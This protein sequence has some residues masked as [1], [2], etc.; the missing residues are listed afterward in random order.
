MVNADGRY[1]G[2]VNYGLVRDRAR[3]KD[4]LA[5]K[6]LGSRQ[7]EYL[8]DTKQETAC[9]VCGI[10]ASGNNEIRSAFRFRTTNGISWPQSWCRKCRTARQH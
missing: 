3:L 9:P 6:L 5:E 10:R 1:G 4:V 2:W 7:S 8:G